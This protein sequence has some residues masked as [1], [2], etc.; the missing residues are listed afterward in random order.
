MSTQ[1]RNVATIAAAVKLGVFT[2]VSVL[3]TGLLAA[4]MG[5]IGFG[6]GQEYTAV[7]TSASM[8]EKGDDV[9]VAGVSVGEVRSVEHHERSQALV[10]F[11][12]KTDVELTTS[13][14]AEIRFLNLVGDRYLA[15]EEGVTATP[16]PRRTPPT[17]S[18][19]PGPARRSTSP[20]SSTGSSRCS[21]RC[22][23]SR[24]TSSRSTW[25]R[26][27]RARAAPSPGCCG[28]PPR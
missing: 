20:R 13:S 8:L 24:S 4:I 15:L 2:V 9:R 18:R 19:R 26:C 6:A 28:A 3:V 27:C 5:N 10:T 11:R 23:P 17:R 22:D 12:V 16:H 14:R 21:R 1:Q 25:S 7:F